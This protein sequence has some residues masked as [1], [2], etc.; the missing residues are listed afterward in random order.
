MTIALL[1]RRAS[2]LGRFVRFSPAAREDTS[3]ASA[4]NVGRWASL[5]SEYTGPRE[6]VANMAAMILR[7]AQTLAFDGINLPHPF[8]AWLKD[9]P[10]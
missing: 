9:A 2:A 4:I 10:R 8:T 6:P 3:P 1:P 7:Y 5:P